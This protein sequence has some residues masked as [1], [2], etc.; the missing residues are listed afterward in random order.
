MIKS[1]VDTAINLHILL[2][3]MGFLDQLS[4]CQFLMD[5]SVVGC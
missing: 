2:K 1:V 5:I 3:V 4:Y